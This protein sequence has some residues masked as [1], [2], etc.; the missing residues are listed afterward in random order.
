MN[1]PFDPE[2][3]LIVVQAEVFGPSGSIVL[4][5][6]L[7]TGATGTM[8]N[9]ALLTAVGYDPSLVPDRVQVTTGSGVE[10]APRI[11]VARIKALGRE[12]SDF[13]VLAHTLPPSASVD[14]LLGLDFLR[15]H[16]VRIDFRQGVVSFT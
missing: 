7:D 16:A 5:L 6:A 13:P 11:L 15:G 8:V 3:G 4:R 12:R 1:Y 10:F 9:V 2:R 14:G